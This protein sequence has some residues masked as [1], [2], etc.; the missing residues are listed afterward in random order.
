MKMPNI[1]ETMMLAFD[2]TT[3]PADL[4]ERIRTNAPAGFTIFAHNSSSAEQMRELTEALQAANPADLPLLIASDQE[5]GQLIALVGTTDFPGNMALGAANDPDLTERVGHAIATEMLALGVNLNYAP[6]ADLN[7]NPANPSLG[8]RAFGDDAARTAPHVAAFVRGSR[9]AGVLTTV[10]HFPGK[11]GAKVDSHFGLPVIEH[12]RERLNNKELVPF[13][14]GLD[15]GA[16]LVMTG[17]FAIPGITERPDIASTLSRAVLTDLL[18]GELGFGGAVITDAFDMGAI[19]QGAGQ[20]IDAITAIN[21]GVDLMLMTAA[22]QERV[23]QGLALASHRLLI[24]DERLAAAVQQSHSLRA[25]VAEFEQPG[26]AVVGSTAHVDLA[27]EA[28][29]KAVTLVGNGGGIL[30]LR[31]DTGQRIAAIMP[32]PKDLTPADTSAKVTPALGDALR[33]HHGIVDEYIVGHPPTDADI[34]AMKSKALEYD[35]VV[36]G[37][38]SASMD[39]QQAQLGRE[40]AATGVPVINVAMRTPYDVNVIPGAAAHVCS[41]GLRRPSVDAAAKALFGAIPFQGSLPVTVSDSL[42]LGHGLTIGAS[43]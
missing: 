41:Y 37:T 20:V 23:E 36:L 3:A 11:G 24:S 15:A 34:R 33:A 32:R 25:W 43:A 2:D 12:S 7:T 35:V 4:L 31:L 16:D 10:K 5:G 39:E 18:R 6:I 8:I 9:S 17:H 40:L 21:A 19:A 30:P 28:A 1:A 29:E 27:R 22:T 13:I 14:A 38:L 42:P 26:L